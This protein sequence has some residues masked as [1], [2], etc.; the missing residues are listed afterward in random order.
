MDGRERVVGRGEV[1]QRNRESG[2]GGE[3]ENDYDTV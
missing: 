1:S 2:E 3:R